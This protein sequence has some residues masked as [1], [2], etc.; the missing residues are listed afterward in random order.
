MKR[1]A[2][3]LLFSELPQTEGGVRQRSQTVEE[4]LEAKRECQSQSQP[5]DSRRQSGEKQRPWNP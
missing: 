3:N 5:D 4:R 1:Q 2:E